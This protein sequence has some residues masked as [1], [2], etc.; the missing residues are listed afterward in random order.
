MGSCRYLAPVIHS[1]AFADHKMA[2]VSGPRQV[3]KTYM[4]KEFL[5]TASNYFSWDETH[6]KRSWVKSP[7]VAIQ[8]AGPGAIVIDE[9]H[10]Y[11][12]WKNSLKGL[13]DRIGRETPILVTGSAKLDLYKRGGDSLMGRY[14]GYRL[15]PFSVAESPKKPPSPDHEPVDRDVRFP[16]K[17]LLILSGF[18][19]PL[20]RGSAKKAE[21]WSRLRLEQTI[22]ND[23]RDFSA[24]HNL[25]MMVL[26]ADLIP[27][28]VASPLS[29]QSLKED[30]Q[31]A[32]AS[33]RSWVMLLET[34]YDCFKVPPYARSI[35][36][37]LRKESKYYL[38]D[39]TRVRDPGARLE[40]L[41]ACHLLK[42]CHYWTD[43]A[44]GKFDLY[45]IRTRDQ[46]EIDFCVVLDGKPFMLVEC[47]SN[48]SAVSPT[49]LRF[50][51]KFPQARAYQLTLDKT[52]RKIPG[53]QVRVINTEKFLAMWM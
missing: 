29:I 12:K 27:E 4:A 31:A 26:L 36:R 39:W 2:F 34:V 30:M 37:S 22:Q 53:T 19:E 41:V 33:V 42:L 51:E 18:P 47:K 52:D 50:S 25:Q 14:L 13:Y 23:I 5:K 32:Y 44:E 8:S 48:A 49:L 35:V 40:N 24:V 3:G 10:K 16:L 20:L 21:R 17:D 43:V 9:I 7:L 46:L 15:H 1:D 11:P 6:F 38:F 28:K 45:Y